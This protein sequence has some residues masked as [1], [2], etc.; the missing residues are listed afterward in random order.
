MDWDRRF[1]RGQDGKEKLQSL[2]MPLST[3]TIFCDA[4]GHSFQSVRH[5]MDDTSREAVPLLYISCLNQCMS[6]LSHAPAE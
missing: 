6:P 2:S 4:T 3:E 5:P 1:P